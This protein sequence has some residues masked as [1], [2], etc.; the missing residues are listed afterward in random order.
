MDGVSD[1]SEDKL[2]SNT[3]T[4]SLPQPTSSKGVVSDD[5]DIITPIHH[6]F[7]PEISAPP[8]ETLTSSE[9]NP[10]KST[11]PYVT[12]DVSGSETRYNRGYSNIRVSKQS[13]PTDVLKKAKVLSL[14]NGR[15]IYVSYWDLG[16]DEVYYATHHIH[17]SPDAVYVCVFDMSEMENEDSR[18]HQLGM[19]LIVA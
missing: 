2:K 3:V 14:S 16:G 13:I 19:Y 9:H 10:P 15:D 6:V 4:T 17:L 7:T 1:E 5:Q 8:P 12:A 18:R 11:A